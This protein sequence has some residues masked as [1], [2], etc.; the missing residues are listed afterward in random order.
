MTGS[1][2]PPPVGFPYKV[3][4]GLALI[5]AMDTFVQLFWKMAAVTLPETPSLE[6][7][8]MAFGQPLF[9]LVVGLMI[10]QLFVWLMVLGEADLSFAQPFFSLSRITVCLASV[11]FLQEIIA[12]AQIVGIALV[13]AGAWCVSRTARNTVREGNARP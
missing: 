7:V 10:C 9:L 2:M 13:C 3:T 8:E 1:S 12:P 5:I 11:Y 4:I 6:G